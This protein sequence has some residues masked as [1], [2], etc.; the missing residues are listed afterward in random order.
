MPRH[1]VNFD[2]PISGV[3]VG[4]DGS[5]RG[6]F[7]LS[8]G[9]A[10]A[11]RRGV[12]LHVVQAW[13]LEDM[14]R[15][16]GLRD[17]VVPSVDECAAAVQADLEAAVAAARSRAGA[18]VAV[19]CHAIEGQAAQMLIDAGGSADVLVVGDRGRGGFAGLVLGSVAEQVVRHARCTVVVA[20]G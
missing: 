16:T 6:E 20:R 8:W 19:L 13:R 18:E 3:V 1:P 9:L 10:D 2:P 5:E 4:Y 15:R 14:L 7:A 17:G 11:V 12:P